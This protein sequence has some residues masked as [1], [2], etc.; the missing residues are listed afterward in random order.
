MPIHVTF[1]DSIEVLKK[2]QIKIR[3]NGHFMKVN[4]I[5]LPVRKIRK[6]YRSV[7][8]TFPSKKNGRNMGFESILERNF[9]LSLEFDSSVQR[10]VEQPVKII[11]Q[12]PDHKSPYHPDCFVSYNNG[13]NCIVEV[14]YINEIESNKEFFDLKFSV[15]KQYAA[16]HSMEF[17]VVTEE[18]LP[19]TVVDNMMFI[20]KNAATDV[21][22]EIHQSILT[23]L[24]TLG[25]STITQLLE[26]L[27]SKK[28]E[29]ARLIPN[30]WKMVFD[31]TILVDLQTQPLTNHSLLQVNPLWKN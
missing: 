21:P 25:P 1:L 24:H 29:Q 14:K 6:N 3:K 13:T 19:E 5:I 12:L 20:Y 31:K 30:L 2:I 11:L 26:T 18:Y 16:D 23:T 10:Y 9:F 22:E 7:T 17:K 4:E 8:G 27:S 15:A 28:L